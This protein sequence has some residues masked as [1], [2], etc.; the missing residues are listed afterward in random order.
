MGLKSCLTVCRVQKQNN[1]VD[2]ARNKGGNWSRAP[3]TK[4]ILIAPWHRKLSHKKHHKS[5]NLQ[6]NK[7]PNFHFYRIYSNI[8][9]RTRILESKVIW[10]IT[11]LWSALSKFYCNKAN[12]VFVVFIYD[13]RD[14]FNVLQIVI[15]LLKLDK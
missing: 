14:M 1:F 4:N 6:A 10:T 3:N 15:F 9:N 5:T 12:N 7:N 8:N 13:F 2:Q 11:V